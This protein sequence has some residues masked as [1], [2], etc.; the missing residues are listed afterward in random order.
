MIQ[1]VDSKWSERARSAVLAGDQRLIWRCGLLAIGVGHKVVANKS[2]GEPA[3]KAFVS[4]KLPA[5]S[6]VPERMIPLQLP[7][8]GGAIRTDVEEMAPPVSPPWV[9]GGPTD[10]WAAVLGNR[11]RRRPVRGGDSLSSYRS[12]IGTAAITVVDTTRGGGCAIV[13]CNH[14]L[15]ELN[16][17]RVGDR[18]VQPALD[19]GGSLFDACAYLD[20]WVPLRFGDCSTAN[21]VDAAIAQV[22]PRC[23]SSWV[24][25]IGPP[26]GVR[27]GGSL[28]PGETV[29]KVGR[30][31]G[32]TAGNVIAVNVSA[33]I[34]YP[35]AFGQV[36]PAFYRDQIVATAM[37]GF[38]DSG[39][40]LLDANDNAVGLLFAGSPTHTFFND[41]THVCEALS[42]RILTR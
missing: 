23:A 36:A 30:T 15:A 33:W 28:S 11:T 7:A 41:I 4:R 35:P 19:D 39:S 24:E 5:E 32:L 12:L 13:S 2:T 21:L 18:I 1:D 22:D 27:P 37:A 14:V 38:G 3:V 26:A 17:G 40:L 8:S 10:P 16:R 6:V 31:T 34:P 29:V 42:I 9:V 25:W 20:R